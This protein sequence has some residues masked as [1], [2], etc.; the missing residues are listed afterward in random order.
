MITLM[1]YWPAQYLLCYA[2]NDK[3]SRYLLISQFL[4]LLL[5]TKLN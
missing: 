3:A 5:K 1:L 4:N 2:V